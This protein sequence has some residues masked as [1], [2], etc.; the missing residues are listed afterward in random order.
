MVPEND[1]VT[2][3]YRSFPSGIAR[4]SIFPVRSDPL[5]TKRVN[6]LRFFRDGSVPVKWFA[7]QRPK[8]LKVSSFPISVGRLPVKLF[9][10]QY[11]LL[12]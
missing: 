5:T 7:C 1:P 2:W 6:R 8:A 4:L 3:R 11:R 12:I 9:D 10:H